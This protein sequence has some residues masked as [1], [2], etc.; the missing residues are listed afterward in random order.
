MK[1]GAPALDIPPSS[2]SP[3]FLVRSSFDSFLCVNFLYDNT[4]VGNF[5][6]DVFQSL[7]SLRLASVNTNKLNCSLSW[8][9][10]FKFLIPFLPYIFIITRSPYRSL[11]MLSLIE[12]LNTFWFGLPS[13]CLI[14][15]FP[16]HLFELVRRVV[17]RC[18][19][20]HNL[21]CKIRPSLFLR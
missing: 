18:M 5:P 17:S 14:C 7:L 16:R 21:F 10:H 6:P 13:L 9:T 11:R 1:R 12:L 4:D 19:V 8:L 2:H 15:L 20:G 3:G